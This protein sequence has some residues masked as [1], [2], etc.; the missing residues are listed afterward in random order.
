MKNTIKTLAIIS[1]AVCAISAKASYSYAVGSSPGDYVPGDQGAVS[2]G[3]TVNDAAFA[4]TLA[5]ANGSKY[6]FGG[7]TL[8]VYAGD[9]L[10]PAGSPLS[11]ASSPFS[12]LSLTGGG[13]TVGNQYAK[14]VTSPDFTLQFVVKPTATPGDL[15]TVFFTPSFSAYTGSGGGTA[16][17]QYGNFNVQ[18]AAVPEPSQ[19]IA[20]AMLLGCGALV[21]TGRRYLSKFAAK[22]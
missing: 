21:F 7:A 12:T 16:P 1:L 17:Q 19:A 4:I 5:G 22:K 9:L 6:T 13:F 20:G 3:S 11:G 14:G 10:V 18:I 15:F 8:S 2:P